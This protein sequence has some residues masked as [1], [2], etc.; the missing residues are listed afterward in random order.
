MSM[1]YAMVTP[2]KIIT[3]MFGK[4]Q[5]KEQFFDEIQDGTLNYYKSAVK[6]PMVVVDG[7]RANLKAKITIATN[8]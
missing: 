3:H 4:K 7:D 2:D 6:D 5:T 8:V 1:L